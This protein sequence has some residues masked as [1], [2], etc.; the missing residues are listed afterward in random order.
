MDIN[1]EIYASPKSLI[2]DAKSPANLHTQSI[3]EEYPIMQDSM[4]KY[5][6]LFVAFNLLLGV[7]AFIIPNTYL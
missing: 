5:Q 3:S 7:G 6:A 4:N 1:S 2:M